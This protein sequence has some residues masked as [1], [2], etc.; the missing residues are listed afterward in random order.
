MLALDLGMLFDTSESMLE[1]LRLTQEA[2]VRFLESIP[3][4]RDLLTIFFDHDIRISRYDSENQQGLFERI[5]RRGRATPPSTTRSPSTC[6]GWRD[7]RAQGAGAVHRR[8]GLHEQDHQGGEVLV[9]SSD[10]VTIYP[11]A[12]LGSF[13]PGSAACPAVPLVPDAV[14]ELSGGEVFSPMASKDLAGSTSD[15]RRA[16]GAVRARLRVG[17]RAPRRQVPQAEGGREPQ[18]ARSSGTAPATTSEGPAGG[19]APA[20]RPEPQPHAQLDKSGSGFSHCARR[21]RSPF[22]PARAGAAAARGAGGKTATDLSHSRL[23]NAGE[24]ETKAPGSRAGDAGLGGDDHAVADRDVPP[25][26]PARPAPPGRRRGAARDPDLRGHHRVRADVTE[27]PICTRLSS[28]VPRPMRVSPR[29]ARS[30]AVRAPISTS[31]STT[32]IPTCGIFW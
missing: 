12:F 22:P 16:R 29:A 23:G 1:Q 3:R 10:A 25:P 15:P 8:R 9:R 2:A 27:W 28:F 31:S 6:P 7:T 14:A 20:A 17:R 26:P 21:Q 18:G 30:I 4:A 19:E 13:R 24:P 11:I 32:T 5:E